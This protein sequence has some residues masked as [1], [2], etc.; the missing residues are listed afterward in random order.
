MKRAASSARIADEVARWPL[1][2]DTQVGALGSQISGGQRQRLAIARA[3]AG[4][5]E[6]L[7]LDEPTSALD[8]TS[9]ALIGE[10]MDSLR[11]NTTIVAIAHRPRTIE[12]ADRIVRVV[13]GTI[14]TPSS[15]ATTLLTST[16]PP[17]RKLSTRP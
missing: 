14:Q 13:D 15:D 7:L 16:Q 6:L 9:E 11:S 4:A 3:I 10:T 17:S 1:G 5:P 2:W 12:H 8:S